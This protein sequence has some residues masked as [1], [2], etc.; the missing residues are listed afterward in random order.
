M[1]SARHAAV[2]VQGTLVE[3]PAGLA[4][5][6]LQSFLERRFEAL[7]AL[8]HPDAD[9]E[10]GFAVPGARFGAKSLL[11]GAWAAA[12]SGAYQP[13]YDFVQTLGPATALVSVT[14]RYEIGQGLLSER[15]AAYLMT[16]KDGLLWRN[17]IFD[18]VE[19][20]LDAHRTGVAG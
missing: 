9:I 2:S 19:E 8:I 12:T 5:S 7:A 14:I 10:A 16:F 18:S 11:D 20:A 17:R 3:T 13:A 4:R 1:S 6:V 15:E